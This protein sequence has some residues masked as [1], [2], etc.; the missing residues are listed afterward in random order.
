MSSATEQLNGKFLDVIDKLH[1]VWDNVGFDDKMRGDRVKS[2]YAQVHNILDQM[3]RCLHFIFIQSLTLQVAEEEEML[4][5]LDHSVKREAAEVDRLSHMLGT[6]VEVVKETFLLAKV[7]SVPGLLFLS[8][9]CF[10]GAH[11]AAQGEGVA[12]DGR[13]TTS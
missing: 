4:E 5:K 12:H 2:V 7:S 13:Q 6:P 3:V 8:P 9:P 1:T 11:S 10:A